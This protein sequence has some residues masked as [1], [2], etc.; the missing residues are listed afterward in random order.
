MQAIENGQVRVNL[1]EALWDIFNKQ[2]EMNL[3][4]QAGRTYAESFQS[5]RDQLI[6]D[7][8][9][10][11]VNA[12]DKL[13]QL[14]SRPIDLNG[15]ERVAKFCFV[16]Q[17]L[18]LNNE[19]KASGVE[20]ADVTLGLIDKVQIEKAELSRALHSQIKELKREACLEIQRVLKPEV[21]N[22]ANHWIKQAVEHNIQSSQR[23][24]FFSAKV[25]DRTSLNELHKG[26]IAVSE[27]LTILARDYQTELGYREST[28]CAQGWDIQLISNAD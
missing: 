2:A 17:S 15:L 24:S 18:G 27:A 5:M 23:Q 7:A 13:N 8:A 12:L 10:K 9:T 3:I 6:F 25:C 4:R 14:R 21:M 16:S 22:S 20:I 1:S 19:S 26:V 28:A 11:R